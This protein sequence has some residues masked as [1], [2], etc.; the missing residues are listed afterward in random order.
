[1]IFIALIGAAL[2]GLAFIAKRQF[3][4]LG[5]ALAAGALISSHWTAILTPMLESYGLRVEFV[6]LSVM[7]AAALIL[8]PPIMLILSGPSYSSGWL[9]VIG[10][11][12]FA[13]LAVVFLLQPLGEVLKLDDQGQAIYNW[14]AANQSIIIVTGLLFA[15]ID[16]MLGLGFKHKSKH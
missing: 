4:I 13:I 5:L 15:T 9:R 12:A 14:V 11:A 3:G 6:P 8:L 1:M 7:V 16:T 10:A 2:F